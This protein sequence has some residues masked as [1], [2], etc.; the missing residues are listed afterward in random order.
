MTGVVQVNHVIAPTPGISIRISRC[1]TPTPLSNGEMANKAYVDSNDSEVRD[2]IN[3]LSGDGGAASSYITNSLAALRAEP[4]V[5]PQVTGIFTATF[6]A[7]TSTPAE[8]SIRYVKAGNIVYLRVGAFTASIHADGT[9]SISTAAAAVPET[10]RPVG[11]PAAFADDIAVFAGAAL[12]P[13]RIVISVDGT[14]TLEAWNATR[15]FPESSTINS[16][17]MHVSYS[18]QAI[19]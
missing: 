15:K 8:Q 2:Y 16:P 13:A 5:L 18:I 19:E 1:V 14:Y 11:T 9:A 7:G 4:Q 17:G 3:S 12:I 10:I 6:I